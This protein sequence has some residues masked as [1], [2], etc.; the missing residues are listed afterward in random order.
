MSWITQLIKISLVMLE[1]LNYI[2]KPYYIKSQQAD[3]WQLIKL[4][5]LLLIVIFI[6]IGAIMSIFDFFL[7]LKNNNITIYNLNNYL[8][9]IVIAPVV[10]EMV[11]RFFLKPKYK[12]IVI[13]I[14][15]M[16][17]L[18]IYYYLIKKHL[19]YIFIILFINIILFYLAYNRRILKKF[20]IHFI[21]FFFIYFNN[22][23]YYTFI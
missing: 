6:P 9:L 13:L 17:I 8:K 20:Q 1:F 7:K 11:F 21:K 3:L 2:K 14:I 5:I 22:L 12:N 10:E 19:N 16:T 18:C 15:F 23:W 4:F